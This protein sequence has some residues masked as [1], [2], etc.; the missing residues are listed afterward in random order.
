MLERKE[1]QTGWLIPTETILSRFRKL[2]VWNQYV[3]RLIA[4]GGSEE[5]LAHASLS[6]LLV[7]LA[8]LGIPWLVDS[9]IWLIL[10]F[11]APQ[12]AS[13]VTW[14]ALPVSVFCSYKDTSLWS[15]AHPHLIWLHWNYVCKDPASKY[16]HIL[17][18]CADMNLRG[19]LFK[20]LLFC[21][22]EFVI[23][24]ELQLSLLDLLSIGDK[25]D[26]VP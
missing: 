12:S 15:R 9:S 13:V 22:F 11:I 21:S 4:S 2:E 19:A 8:L 10:V 1:L 18:F 5:D 6:V 23:D 3:S 7:L 24:S 25:R 20:P 26:P 14:S 17:R 16:G